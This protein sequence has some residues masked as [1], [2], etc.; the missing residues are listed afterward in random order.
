MAKNKTLQAIVEI[1]GTLSPTLEKSIGSVVDKLDKINLKAVAVGAAVATATVAATTA[2]VNF[3]EQA[4]EAAASY[5]KAF[6]AASTLMQGTEEELKAI[7]NDIIDVSN[8]TGI[9]AEDL[10][11]SVYSAISAGID[12]EEAVEFA[13]KA[14]KLEAAGFTDV[15]TALSATAKTLNAYEMEADKADEIQKVLIQTQNL[16]ITTVGELGASLAQVTPTAAAFGVSFDQVGASLA[17]MTAQ[18]TPTAQATTQLN[19]L[20]AE[21]A[22]NGTIAANNLS[23]AAEGTEYAGMSFNDMMDSGA[24]LADVL[25][26]IQN[27]ADESGVSMVDMFSSIEAGKAALAIYSGEGATFRDDMA[28]MVT[29]ADVVGAA[30]DKVTGTFEHQMEVLQNLGQNAKISFGERLLPI[31]TEVAQ[32]AIPL[33]EDAMDQLLPVFD[34]IGSNIM[35]I[36]ESLLPQLSPLIGQLIPPV[37]SLAST[38]ASQV[39]PPIIK[40]VTGLAPLLLTFLN[41]VMPVMEILAGEILPVVVNLVET[42]I[43]PIT[44]IIMTVLPVVQQMLE[45]LAPIVTKLF[46]ALSPILESIGELVAALLPPL[47]SIIEALM[48]ILTF[49]ANIIVTV[50]ADAFRQ[51]EPI[52]NL[53]TLLISGFADQIAVVFEGLVGIVKGPINAVI[54]LVNSAIGKINEIS[55]DIPDWVP[56]VGGQHFGFNLPEIPM[57]AAGGF[58]DG[59]SIAG[60]AGREAVISFDSVYR[61]AN[62][63]YWAQAGRMLGLYGSNT[64]SALAGELLALDDFSLSGLAGEGSTTIYDF[65]GMHYNPVIQTQNAETGDI[66]QQLRQHADEFMDWLSAWTARKG[67]VAYG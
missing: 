25:E 58:T 9:A 55:V 5:E 56:L 66:M 19:G 15:D 21:L 32:T 22:K 42:L 67:R 33:L 57:L 47:I 45:A 10:A 16:G 62:I 46:T 43:P 27:S 54:S 31:V 35:L 23:K 14:A 29:D 65:S 30:Y 34:D 28:A 8:E 59:L 61:R 6:A 26:L 48:P 51:L 50:V 60:E 13:G 53:I 11:N 3:S 40:I 41:A 63:G 7:S 38:L 36:V 20:I 39:L 52:I 18:G 17:V 64:E 37:I 2:F 1:A 12:Q 49:V 4:V 44:T 24:N